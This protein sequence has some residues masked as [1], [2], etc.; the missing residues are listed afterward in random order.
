ML[1]LHIFS[2]LGVRRFL[3]SNLKLG[4]F[5][6]KKLLSLYIEF[7][8]CVPSFQDQLVKRQKGF[9]S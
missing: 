7:N 4:R 3:C 8:K 1:G 9:I 6:V 5:V 2:I